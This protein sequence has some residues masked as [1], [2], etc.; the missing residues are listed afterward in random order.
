MTKAEWLSVV[1]NDG[2]IAAGEKST[3]RG[4]VVLFNP[5]AVAPEDIWVQ[6]DSVS[7]EFVPGL[8]D[9]HWEQETDTL[10]PA[11]PEMFQKAGSKLPPGKRV[12]AIGGSAEQHVTKLHYGPHNITRWLSWCDMRAAVCRQAITDAV[13]WP[14]PAGL[15]LPKAWYYAHTEREIWRQACQ[16]T[17]MTGGVHEVLTGEIRHSCSEAGAQG[18]AF[19]PQ[20]LEYDWQQLLA[21]DERFPGMLPRICPADVFSSTGLSREFARLAGPGFQPGIPVAP[22]NSDNACSLAGAYGACG[23]AAD[24]FCFISGGTSWTGT[25]VAPQA[26]IDTEGAVLPFITTDGK[27]EALCCQVAGNQRVDELVLEFLK[28]SAGTL[29]QAGEELEALRK[30]ALRRLETR[31]AEIPLTAFGKA[32]ALPFTQGDRLP[33]IVKPLPSIRWVGVDEWDA[34]HS[35]ALDR[36][37]YRIKLLQIALTLNLV[38]VG[39]SRMAGFGMEFKAIVIGGGNAASPLWGNLVAGA[40]GLPVVAMAQPGLSALIGAGFHTLWLYLKQ[41]WG[42]AANELTL[43]EVGSWYPTGGKSFAPQSADEPFWVDAKERY[44]ALLAELLAVQ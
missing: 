4:Q 28:E 29:P 36:F 3:R 31:A 42:A 25:A 33:L 20:K 44:Q 23:N 43:G 16:C 17:L 2:V 30:E 34:N 32:M 15:M 8:P 22:F 27:H 18:L 38:Q 10:A 7:F 19:D 26:F 9:G 39:F 40:T 12:I 21:V 37:A 41:Q 1:P 24:A 6:G 5:H 11:L 14:V 13:G 35:E